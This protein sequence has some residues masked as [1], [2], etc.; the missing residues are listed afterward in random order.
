MKK[1][2]SNFPK[3]PKKEKKSLPK[4]FYEKI[5]KCIV[6]KLKKKPRNKIETLKSWTFSIKSEANG[7]NR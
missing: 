7:K 2:K 6:A 1:C 4:K 5:R 3:R